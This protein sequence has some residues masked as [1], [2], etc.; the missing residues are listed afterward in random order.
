MFGDA[1]PVLQ[2]ATRRYLSIEQQLKGK[3]FHE[4]E[5][6]VQEVTPKCK[7]HNK[8][9]ASSLIASLGSL[10]GAAVIHKEFPSLREEANAV[11]L[12]GA[13]PMIAATFLYMFTYGMGKGLTYS[14]QRQIAESLLRQR[15]NGSSE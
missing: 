13:V 4:L 12:Y 11:A 3:P 8:I 7:R 15:K 1:G 10:I 9:T 6:L 5:Q 14:Y 2:E